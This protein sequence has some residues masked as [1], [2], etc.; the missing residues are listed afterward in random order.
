MD[1]LY[2]GIITIITIIVIFL[3]IIFGIFLMKVDRLKVD[4]SIRAFF[5]ENATNTFKHVMN[6]ITKLANVETIIIITIPIMF[7]LVEEKKYITASSIIISIIFSVGISQLLKFLF[8][9]GRPTKSKEFEYIGYSFPSGHSTV[10]MAY[11]LTLGLIL[12]QGSMTI[13]VI[14]FTLGVLIGISRLVLGV[15]WFT[16]VIT[17]LILGLICSYWSFYLYNIGYY[18]KWLFI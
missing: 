13:A 9:V 15:H 10:G 8:K 16:D 12:S 14:T 4:L 2:I 18:I 1:S 3:I 17:G 7:Y 6:M 5:K 11:Y